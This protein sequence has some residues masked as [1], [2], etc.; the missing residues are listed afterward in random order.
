MEYKGNAQKLVHG[1]GVNDAEYVT[2]RWGKVN[3]KH[4]C[5]WR[6][7]YYV[8]WSSM[9]QRCYSEK[10]QAR[11]PE[12]AGCTVDP[13]WHKFSVFR[14]WMEGQEW[15]G[16]QLDKDLLVTGNRVYSPGTCA[17]VSV[18]VNSFIT[19]ASST[20]G[21]FPSGVCFDKVRNKYV[22]YCRNP[23]TKK[24]EH[25]GGF[26]CPDAAHKAWKARKHELACRFANMQKDVRA[27]DALRSR[28]AA[29]VIGAQP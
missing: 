2:H 20:R 26:Q 16:K 22:S 8:T 21:D 15:E 1:V 29:A 28:Y 13:S 6:C 27:A 12:Y 5:V 17:F 25:L 10:F 14:D 24:Q 19:D 9:L 11:K 18:T 23:F 4:R 7:P 3:G